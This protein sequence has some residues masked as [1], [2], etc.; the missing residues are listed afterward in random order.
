MN[1]I[2]GYIDSCRILGEGTAF[3]LYAN[4]GKLLA[5]IPRKDFRKMLYESDG[6]EWI[7]TSEADD[8]RDGAKH[9]QRKTEDFIDAASG[10]SNK[11]GK[12][13]HKNISMG[14]EDAKDKTAD[15][16]D[17]LKGKIN[18][19][20]KFETLKKDV[21]KWTEGVKGKINKDE[22]QK[23]LDNGMHWIKDPGHIAAVAATA[24]GIAA[25]ILLAR[26]LAK[27]GKIDKFPA[28]AKTVKKIKKEGKSLK[29]EIELY[30][31]LTE[32]EISEIAPN[33][34]L[35]NELVYED[36]ET[37]DNIIQF[38]SEDDDGDGNEGD[39]GK[40]ETSSVKTEKDKDKKKK[41]QG[42]TGGEP[43]VEAGEEGGEAP[44]SV[45]THPKNCNCKN[46]LKKKKAAVEVGG[47]EGDS[48]P[49]DKKSSVE[50]RY[51]HY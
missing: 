6:D 49:D 19:G 35:L 13:M 41:R 10:E 42:T 12:T 34:S 3:S 25:I 4:L 31:T 17:D 50:S 7:S 38:I 24:S 39:D 5:G 1:F 43:S 51:F 27:K 22:I 16:I 36:Q 15:L 26:A 14:V 23:Y 20:G 9:L 45:K 29:E 28:L 30:D 21:S 44:S 47:T 33:L 40:A 18:D 8:I 46:C 2:N 48:T 32:S 37:F 11:V